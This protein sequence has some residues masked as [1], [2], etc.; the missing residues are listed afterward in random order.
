MI[1][2]SREYNHIASIYSLCKRLLIILFAVE[3]HIPGKP[4]F[5]FDHVSQS[6]EKSISRLASMDIYIPSDVPSADESSLLNLLSAYGNIMIIIM[7]ITS[8][9]ASRYKLLCRS[10]LIMTPRLT[11]KFAARTFSFVL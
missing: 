10:E 1:T 4:L 8:L 11:I 5:I 6:V 9:I 3:S 7:I 2:Y